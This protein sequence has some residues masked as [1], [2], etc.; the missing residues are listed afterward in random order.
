MPKTPK[1]I[2]S[3]VRGGVRWVPPHHTTDIKPRQPPVKEASCADKTNDN[4]WGQ[5]KVSALFQKACA[6]FSSPLAKRKY[7]CL[8]STATAK[9]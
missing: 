4:H 2:I 5:G 3:S 1:S 8:R 6:I 7:S 9:L